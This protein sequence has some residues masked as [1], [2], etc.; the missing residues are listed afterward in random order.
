MEKSDSG[1]TVEETIVTKEPDS[2]KL[3]DRKVT[4]EINAAKFL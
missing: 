1:A 4:I 2:L 3:I